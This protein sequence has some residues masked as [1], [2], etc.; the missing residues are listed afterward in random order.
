M[1]W[2]VS[3]GKNRTVTGELPNVNAKPKFRRVEIS[4]HSRMADPGTFYL[5]LTDDLLQYFHQFR[6]TL[7]LEFKLEYIN[8][9]SSK[10]IFQMLH[11]IQ[12][13][14]SGKGLVQV[15]WHYEE[16]DEVILQAGEILR[17]SLDLDFKLIEIEG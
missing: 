13:K 16:D 6:K 2:F 14:V 4:G 17:A 9:G 1:G 12:Q 15:Y 8:T 7:I 3:N 11:N 5:E 10:W